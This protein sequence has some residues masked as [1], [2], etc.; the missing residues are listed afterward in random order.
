MNWLKVFFTKLAPTVEAGKPDE[1][2]EMGRKTASA[3]MDDLD[4]FIA[5][6][7]G[8]IRSAYLKVLD[9]GLLRVSALRDFEHSPILL[10][11]AEL[12]SFYAEVEDLEQKMT[13]EI[14]DHMQA[15]QGVLESIG[16]GGTLELATKA[17]LEELVLNMKSGGLSLLL[18]RVDR[19]K[20]LDDAWRAAN[21]AQS[22]LEPIE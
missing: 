10:A 18:E 12:A 3:M 5:N 19:L 2:H 13:V 14:Y 15:W 1:S 11:R 8:H 22:A 16:L 17:R 6:R 7:F 4:G 20:I 21:P 9:D